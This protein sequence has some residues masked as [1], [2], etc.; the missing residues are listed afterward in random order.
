MA[1]VVFESEVKMKKAAKEKQTWTQEFVSSQVDEWL[2]DSAVLQDAFGTLP[3]AAVFEEPSSAEA[4]LHCICDRL[5]Q[6]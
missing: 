3:K 2:K 5:C 4:D 1:A 6:S